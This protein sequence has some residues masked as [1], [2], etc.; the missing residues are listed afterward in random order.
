MAL[1]F[2]H[3]FVDEKSFLKSANEAKGIQPVE[4]GETKVVKKDGFFVA[5]VRVMATGLVFFQLYTAGFGFFPNIIQRSIHIGVILFL[6]FATMPWRKGTDR[7]ARPSLIDAIIMAGVLTSTAYTVLSYERIVM[8]PGNA[9]KADLVMAIFIII[10]ILE[11]SRRA[12]G[13]VFPLLIGGMFVYAF[14]GPVLPGVWA[15]K[16]FS[17]K[18]ILETLYMTTNGVW[19]PITGISAT[20]VAIFVIFGA[21]LLRTGG[22]K[23]FIDI[24]AWATQKTTGGGPKMAIL[25]S[26]LFAT[27]N[28]NGPANVA[29]TG[30]FTIPMIKKMGYRSE[31]AAAVEATASTGGQITP[32]IMGAGAFVMAEL[33]GVPYAK[34]ALSGV[35]P[36]LL[37]YLGVF[38]SVHSYVLR[39][40]GQNVQSDSYIQFRNIIGF[41]KVIQLLLPLSILIILLIRGYTP[42]YAAFGGSVAAIIV[43]FAFSKSLQDLRIRFLAC[44]KALE[45]GGMGLIQIGILVAS[46][47]IVVTLISLTGLS[48][49]MS[50]LL[51]T[52]TGGQVGLSLFLTMLICVLMGM[53][54]P[55]VAAYILCATVCA[56]PLVS[57]GLNPL[58]VHMFVFYFAVM[59]AVTPPVCT[60]V[61]VASSIASSNWSK[62]AKLSVLL[63]L[64]GFIVPFVFIYSPGMLLQ[65][66]SIDICQAFMSGA[67]GVI[68][69]SGA[70]TGYLFGRVNP[71]QRGLLYLGAVASLEPSLVGDILGFLF[72]GI[73]LC[74][75]IVAEKGKFLESA[76]LKGSKTIK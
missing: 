19:G 53:G 15:H 62:T 25:A 50:Q 47:Q 43:Y 11:G 40:Y 9:G 42:A 61:Y 64:P 55:T 7:S 17:L 12:L 70:I 37:F 45:S 23:T 69:L 5:F 3:G 46:A 57:I 1:I 22:G 52:L 48:V 56:P 26:T 4:E 59:S 51:F 8:N 71:I 18:M 73:V 66:T 2:T 13:W 27:I 34:I 32:P 28:G 72:L 60:S 49:K 14:A 36:S 65:G 54:V 10:V 31:F 74:W 44:L 75:Q 38:S 33:I 68:A 58:L 21:I 24:S 76:T 16:G 41:E 6:G 39:D 63:A 67:I 30:T 35:I 20:I 29:A